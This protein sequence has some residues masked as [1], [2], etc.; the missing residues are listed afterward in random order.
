ME[1]TFLSGIQEIVT[2]KIYFLV[3]NA[4][5]RAFSGVFMQTKYW[6]SHL[7]ETVQLSTNEQTEAPLFQPDAKKMHWCNSIPVTGLYIYYKSW[8]TSHVTSLS[9]DM[10]KQWSLLCSLAWDSHSFHAPL[11]CGHRWVFW[12]QLAC[13]SVQIKET[14]QRKVSRKKSEGVRIWSEGEETVP[15]SPSSFLPLFLPFLLYSLYFAPLCTN[16]TS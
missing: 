3:A 7:V 9:L 10:A 6:P 11:S 4:D 2:I 8:W 12:R 15:V 14:A 16:W 13:S 1:V 5:Q